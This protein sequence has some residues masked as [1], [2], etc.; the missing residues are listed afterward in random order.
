M[1]SK[2]ARRILDEER[3]AETFLGAIEVRAHHGQRIL[4]VRQRQQVI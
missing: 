1:E 2:V 4:A 3:T